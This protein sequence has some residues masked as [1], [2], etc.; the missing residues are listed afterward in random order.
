MSTRTATIIGGIGRTLISLGLITLSFAA[1]QLWGTGIQE[2]RAQASLEDDFEQRLSEVQAQASD[3]GLDMSPTTTAPTSAGSGLE[4]G[5]EDDDLADP[6]QDDNPV[7][8]A[9]TAPPITVDPLLQKLLSVD[10]G[11]VVGN[12]S[13]PAIGLERHM[14]E[15]IQRDHLRDGP[16]HY[17]TSPLP[18]QP[19]NSA[20]AG[21]RTTYGEP[22]ADIDLLSPG[23]EIVMTTLQGVFTYKVMPHTSP[24]GEE[25]GHF[26]VTPQQ[27]EILQDYGDNRLTLTACHPKYSA[28]QRIV[29]T[30]LLV[31]APAPVTPTTVPPVDNAEVASEDAVELRGDELALDEGNVVGID[32][33]ALS[34][35]LGWNYDERGPT[36]LWGLVTAIIALIAVVV[37]HLWK[38]WASYVLA[39]PV[40]LSSLFVCFSHLDKFLPAL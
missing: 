4:V 19:G 8:L 9:E 17:P 18:G 29:V 15:G 10:Q 20:V 30:A 26:I 7:I 27:V 31:E 3:L 25:V 5:T 40:F 37:G 2:A 24:E 34:E 33:N 35:S 23:D 38:R 6:G 36:I 28:R 12:I 39:T 11:S 21:H 13:I 16:G 32:E 14:V 1:F 22:F